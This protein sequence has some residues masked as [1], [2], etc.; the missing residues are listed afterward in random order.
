M[1]LSSIAHLY[2]VR[3]KV[4]LVLVQELLAVLGL[5]VGVALLFAS[6]VASAS[7]DGSV[8]Q[9]ASQLVG[10]MQF[11]LQSR[12]P[13][14]FD[15]SLLGQVRQL[16]GVSAALPL[17][18]RPANA[19]GPTGRQ[20][21]ELI[22]A[23]P[24]LTL[25]DSPLLK[26]FHYA[27]LARLHALALPAPVAEKIGAQPLQPIELQIGAS[28]VTAL[29]GTSL[30][31]TAIGGLAHSPVAVAPLAYAQKLTGMRGRI[32]RIYV[33]AIPGREL[34]VRAGLQRLA[35]GR[36]NVEPANFDV[37]LFRV[38]AA[39]ANQGE[40]LFSGISALVGFL[41]A[42]NAMLLTLPLRQ[43]LIAGL[44]SNGATRLDIVE[45]LLFDAAVLGGLAALLGL[46][47]GDLLSIVVFRS[48]PGYLSFAFPVG[49]QRVVTWQSIAIAAGAGLAA[50]CIGVLIP[51]R[52][53]LSTS[54]Q[55]AASGRGHIRRRWVIG[56]VSG[57]LLCLAATTVILLA[58]PQSAVLGSVLLVI[59]LLLLLP[60]LLYAVVVI[61]DRLQSH[62]GSASTR[63]A[64]IE[65]RSPKTRAR[66]LAIAATGAIAVFGSVAIQG[67]HANLQKGLDRLV[68]QLSASADLWVTPSGAENLL[69][70]T[71][72][73]NTMASTLARLP[74]VRAV[75]LY[76]ASFL[77]YGDRRIWVLAP[78]LSARDPIPPSQLVTGD[79]TLA[80]ARLR[81]GGWAVVSQAIAAQD[82]LHIGQRFTL[83]CPYPRT[84]RVAALTT[85][86]GWPPGAIILN[87]VDYVR[88][89]GSAEPSAYTITLRAG[90]PAQRGRREVQRALAAGSA[91]TVQTAQQREA[92][93][94][95]SSR[96]GLSRLTQ[97]ATLVLI[98][99]VLAMSVAMGTMIW[100]RRPRLA[101]MKVQ[102]FQHGVLWRALIFESSLLLGAG[103]LIGAVFGIYGQLLISHALA[104]VTGF[105]VV[106]SVGAVIAILSSVLVSAVAV[107]IVALPG[108]RAARV[109]PYV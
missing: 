26:H 109:A 41:F 63:V 12:D 100:Q 98:A 74:G 50:A 34:Q 9:L 10:N 30:D 43:G 69:A 87:P 95:A 67:A 21:I 27:Q 7:L 68:H 76:R 56:A 93:Q 66:S 55:T 35:A 75:G 29:V 33:Q 72:F 89:W 8:Q 51:L 84:F 16:P 79:L 62:F 61:F 77:D 70:T 108:Y 103:C 20:A 37:T 57:G 45:A 88:A 54:S 22:G 5:S 104:S 4:R 65:L 60:L 58:A 47:L 49:T 38:A 36:L 13:R 83:P 64:I 97:I 91:L 53:I 59:A 11:Q 107:A 1:R 86:L 3:L 92:L 44:R 96:Q 78:S 102:G 23:D 31:T 2:R 42:L 32:T 80:T 48:N 85:N 106:I 39:P 6:Q 17:L 99:T 101:R 15:E 46:A 81:M 94:Q 24:R 28:N 40:S 52:E 73:P 19:I 82:H 90:I 105:P 14:G 25:R 18:E 71:P